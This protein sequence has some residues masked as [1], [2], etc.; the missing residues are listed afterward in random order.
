MLTVRLYSLVKYFI[1]VFLLL[2]TL[3]NE[4]WLRFGLSNQYKV[5][6]KAHLVVAISFGRGDF[7]NSHGFPTQLRQQYWTKRP[8][9]QSE[10]FCMLL[11]SRALCRP[12]RFISSFT[13]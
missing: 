6:V 2:A 7:V 10:E 11:K 8:A 9:S 1:F 12:V 3:A 4:A 5:P 13:G